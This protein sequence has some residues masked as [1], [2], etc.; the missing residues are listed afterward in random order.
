MNKDIKQLLENFANNHYK[1]ILVEILRNTPLALETYNTACSYL[2]LCDGIGQW[3]LDGCGE[4]LWDKT[5]NPNEWKLW[6]GV[7]SSVN[8]GSLDV[9]AI[10]AGS[11]CSG[12]WFDYFGF[13]WDETNCLFVETLNE[14]GQSNRQVFFETAWFYA[15]R[16]N[17]ITVLNKMFGSAPWCTSLCNPNFISHFYFPPCFERSSPEAVEL[18]VQSKAIPF[19]TILYNQL[20]AGERNEILQV[21]LNHP[22]AT[23]EFVAHQYIHHW[24]TPYYDI[25]FSKTLNEFIRNFVTTD[26]LNAFHHIIVHKCFVQ[27]RRDLP[28]RN[29]ELFV[30]HLKNTPLLDDVKFVCTVLAC[31]DKLHPK[32]AWPKILEL[33]VD[34]LNPSDWGSVVDNHSNNEFLR[35]LPRGQNHILLQHLDFQ[36]TTSGQRK[37]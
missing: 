31:I 36:C 7:K 14:K 26:D 37:I 30:K 24:N 11:D 21:L 32:T 6:G 1:E 8:Y 22:Q 17:N 2:P 27:N 25:N 3:I 4:Y 12:R 18:L 23:P 33:F 5:K 28:Y 15:I 10:L 34:S 13:R 9:D 19:E 35:G 20:Q 16:T 29:P